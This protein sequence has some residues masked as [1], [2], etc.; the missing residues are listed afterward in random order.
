MFVKTLLKENAPKYNNNGQQAEREVRYTL[1]GKWY[2]ADNRKG[3]ADCNG[4]QVKSFRATVCNGTTLNGIAEEYADVDGFIFAD[5]ETEQM[6]VM[7]A[8]EWFDFCK[9]FAEADN[10]S[11][12]SNGAKAKIR[13]NRQFKAQREWL[14]DRT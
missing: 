14:R 10:G 1:T 5:R 8:D 7:T 6:F 4:Y 2:N 12:T 9:V 11:K 3:G 13:L